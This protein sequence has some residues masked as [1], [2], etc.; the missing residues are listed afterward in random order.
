MRRLLRSV[1][2]A[3]AIAFA[4][5]CFTVGILAG[6]LPRVAGRADVRERR[7]LDL[8][9][10]A[11]LRLNN[12]DG[13]VHVR[14]REMDGIHLQASINAYVS[15]GEDRSIAQDYVASLIC[16]TLD[17]STL[18]VVTEPGE[19]PDAVDVRV[20]YTILVPLGTDVAIEGYNG[21]VWV[22]KGCGRVS[23]AGRNT[24]IEIVEPGGPVV[25]ESTNGRIRVMDA[26]EGATIRTVN[27]NVYAHMLGG[28]LEAT[29]TNGAI[30]AH[31][32][33]PEVRACDLS[34]RNGGITLVMREDWSAQVEAVTERGVVKSDFPVDSASGVR[35]RR[36]LRGTIGKGDT[37]LRMHTLNGNIWIARSD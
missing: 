28:P 12:P 27:G 3:G 14:A 1:A 35:R 22:S 19:R 32:L 15:P 2:T 6:N 20:D 9:A 31:V 25:A 5:L 29:T 16:A 26:P 34:S 17:G 30:V 37:M 24:D 11:F 18:D 36:H 13:S 33:D 10:A 21:N 23:V 8:P 4:V 7:E